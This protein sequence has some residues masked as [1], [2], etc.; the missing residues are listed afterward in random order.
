MEMETLK[1]ETLEKVL[2]HFGIINPDSVEI[3]EYRRELHDWGDTFLIKVYGISRR[4][5]YFV[6]E[7]ERLYF[8]EEDELLGTFEEWI[9]LET[10]ESCFWVV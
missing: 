2:E 7:D 8:Y 4:L 3:V 9:N 1:K 6:E 10:G 5:K